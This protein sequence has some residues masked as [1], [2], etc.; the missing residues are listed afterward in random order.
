MYIMLSNNQA[1]VNSHENW[2]MKKYESLIRK[3][4]RGA[5][6]QYVRHLRLIEKERKGERPGQQHTLAIQTEHDVRIICM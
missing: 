5:G 1:D 2:C 3:K 4:V 6:V